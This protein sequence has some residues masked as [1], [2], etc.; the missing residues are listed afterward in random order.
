MLYKVIN[1]S[2]W[3]CKFTSSSALQ[4]YVT[5]VSLQLQILLFHSLWVLHT[6]V[7]CWSLNDS[8]SPQ[9]SGIKNAVIWIVSIHSPISD[10]FS[11]LSKHLGNIPSVPI[12]NG[13]PSPSRFTA[14]SVSWPVSLFSFSL[15]FTLWST[16]M[17]KSKFSFL[18]NYQ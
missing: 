11:P 10:S 16:G 7:S 4:K 12:P 3:F 17:A 8:K 9:A 6:S 18:V 13:S 15:I 2:F 5:V 1:L 14:F